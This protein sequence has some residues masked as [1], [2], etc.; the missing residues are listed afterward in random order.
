MRSPFALPLVFLLA[1][2]G[3]DRPPPAPPTSTAA[4]EPAS[5]ATPAATKPSPYPETARRPVTEDYFG[6]KATDDYRWL[7]DPKDPNVVAWTD[8]QNKLTRS[9]LDAIADRPKIRARVAELLSGRPPSFFDVRVSNEQVFAL[10]NQP[11]KQQ[12]FLVLYT[13]PAKQTERVVLDP[14]TLDPSGKTAIDFFVA[15]RDGKKVMVSLSMGGSEAGDAHVYDVASGKAL[16]D[17]I[18]HVNGGT[19]GG[20]VAWNA[21]GSGFFYTRY[22]REGERAKEDLEFYQQVYFNKLGT[23][24]EADSYV[25]GKDLP[26]IA[27]IFLKTSDDGK[28]VLAMVQNGD[29][30]EFA[31]YVTD[32]KGAFSQIARFEDKIIRANFGADGALYM[33]S[34]KGTPKGALVR[35]KKPFATGKPEMIVPEGDGVIQHY[36]A[37]KSRLYVAELLGGPSRLRSFRLANGKAEAPEVIDVAFKIPAVQ[38]L[39][40]IGADDVLYSAESYTDAPGWFRYAAA[41]KKSTPTVLSQTMPYSMDDVEVVRETYTSKDGAQVPLNVLRK[42]GLALDGSHPTLLTGYGGYSVSRTPR[43]RPLNRFW[44]DQGG[45]FAEAN[46]RGGGEY[47]E[48]WHEAGKLANKQNVFDDFY[49]CAKALEDK[50]YTKPAHLGI[51]GGSNGGLLMGAEIVQHPEAF[52]AVVSMVGIYDMLRVETTPNGA[53]NVTEFGTVKDEK[54]FRA[55]FAYSPLQNAKDG[56]AYPAI[57]FTSGANDPRVD[58][59]HSRKM[60]ARLQRATTSDRPILLRASADVGHGIGTPLGAEIEEAADMYAFVMN[61]LGVAFVR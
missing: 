33:L 60:V 6:T 21:D 1:C 32:E 14:N 17:V 23:K 30:G 10:K 19:A 29:G 28:S 9:R 24:V 57:L 47:G 53:F 39:A 36:A 52:R 7:E 5:A 3:A 18:P 54:L 2:G 31:F 37:T 41:T 56:V 42:R 4:K 12:P 15:S 8:A 25:L 49:A 51:Y 34:R 40:R 44:L 11:P 16:P 20:S 38:G 59:Y 48:A 26:R 46:L 55:L 50:G 22:P 43:L 45:V 61:E 13:D 27:E 35:L 58:P